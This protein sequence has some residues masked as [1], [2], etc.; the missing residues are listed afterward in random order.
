MMR[1]PKVSLPKDSKSL[2]QKKNKGD[3]EKEAAFELASSVN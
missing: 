3:D 1:M 2:V